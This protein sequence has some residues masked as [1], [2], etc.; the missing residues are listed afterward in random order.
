[1]VQP[2]RLVVV[3]RSVRQPGTVESFWALQDCLACSSH[4]DATAVRSAA[5]S[6]A[7]PTLTGEGVRV[8]LAA[9][10]LENPPY[11]TDA[12]EVEP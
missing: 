10:G 12:S 9:D 5:F 1:M 4:G 8:A 3:A 11:E 2:A 7:E 6:V